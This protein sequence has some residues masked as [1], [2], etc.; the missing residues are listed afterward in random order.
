MDFN[1][2]TQQWVECIVEYDA[3]CGNL[4]KCE[5]KVI[6]SNPIWCALVLLF[7]R[8]TC[9]DPCPFRISKQRLD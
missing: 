6:I 8:V 4:E 3:I 5:G 7:F 2:S 9:D 1:I